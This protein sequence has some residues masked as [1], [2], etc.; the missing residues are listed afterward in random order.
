MRAAGRSPDNPLAL[1]PARLCVLAAAA[2]EGVPQPD[3][4]PPEINPLPRKAPLE[5]H[6]V[7]VRK[8]IG[9]Q[10][11]RVTYTCGAP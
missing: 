6:S 9:V 2:D 8:K 10:Q 3:P 5:G 4:H 1:L 11:R 7:L